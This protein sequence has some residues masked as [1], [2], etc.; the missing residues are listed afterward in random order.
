MSAR[1]FRIACLAWV[2][3]LAGCTAVSR[4]DYVQP[5]IV[6]V[7]TGGFQKPMRAWV[8][9]YARLSA[10]PA[11]D[12]RQIY[13]QRR[14]ELET[15]ECGEGAIEILMLLTRPD[16]AGDL[17]FAENE[18][19]LEGCDAKPDWQG[20]DVAVLAPLLL[21]QAALVNRQGARERATSQELAEL[22]RQVQALKEV[23]RSLQR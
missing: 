14:K 15:Y 20:S 8:E 23:E 2:A 13:R 1:R 21:K 4:N 19:L 7:A 18:K 10:M 17:E 11:R 9:R 5:I 12:A 16:L 6:P 3:A 22:R